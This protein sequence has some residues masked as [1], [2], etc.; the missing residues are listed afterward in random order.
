[1]FHRQINILRLND[2]Q[3]TSIIPNFI[4]KDIQVG[5]SH[6]MIETYQGKKLLVE[7]SQLTEKNFEIKTFTQLDNKY[8]SKFITLIG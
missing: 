7:L 3:Q 1:M 6:S 4:L 5:S 2:N 8:N